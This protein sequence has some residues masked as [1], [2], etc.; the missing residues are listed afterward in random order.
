M[1]TLW[2]SPASSFS[3]SSF[4]AEHAQ[5]GGQQRYAL[6]RTAVRQPED[7]VRAALARA[8]KQRERGFIELGIGLAERVQGNDGILEFV[9]GLALHGLAFAVDAVDVAAA[10]ILGGFLDRA[11]D[12]AGVDALDHVAGA[13]A[14]RRIVEADFAG[15]RAACRG[16]E[17][18]AIVAAADHGLALVGLGHF[19]AGPGD[20][21]AA[22]DPRLVRRSALLAGIGARAKVDGAGVVGPGLD[23]PFRDRAFRRHPRNICGADVDFLGRGG[24]KA[25]ERAAAAKWIAD[26]IPGLAQRA[27]G[28]ASCGGAGGRAAGIRRQSTRIAGGQ[29]GIA[30]ACR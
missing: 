29:S 24:L 26:E 16:L 21:H 27:L 4:S 3:S 7:L 17:R 28:K 22:D 15:L 25:I 5:P 18:A 19:P 30:A 12:R 10:D 11:R 6:A 1:P 14:A 20:C 8:A 2:Q 9:G 23:E 13:I